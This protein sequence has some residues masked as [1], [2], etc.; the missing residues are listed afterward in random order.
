MAVILEKTAVC[1]ERE[2]A[3][4]VQSLGMSNLLREHILQRTGFLHIPGFFSIKTEGICSYTQEQRF[5]EYRYVDDDKRYFCE[6]GNDV[7]IGSD[8]I[9]LQGVKIGNGAI[10]A[11][12]AVVTKDVPDFAIV[13]GVPAKI[14]RYRFTKDEINFLNQ[15]QWWNRQEKWIQNHALYFSDIKLLKDRVEK[16]DE[17]KYKRL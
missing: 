2:L 13:G 11:S 15:L 7:W 8:V 14:I 16:S 1:Q 4:T 5:E 3:N 12:G 17:R 10:V 6:I 9:I